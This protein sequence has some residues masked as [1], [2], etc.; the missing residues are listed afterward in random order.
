[1]QWK[2]F[3]IY[4]LSIS[5]TNLAS[6]YLYFPNSIEAS[7]LVSLSHSGPNQAP[8]H[9]SLLTLVIFPKPKSDGHSPAQTF[10]SFSMH[11]GYNLSTRSYIVVL[12]SHLI[13]IG[14]V[15]TLLPNSLVTCI[16]SSVW[17]PEP[18]MLFSS[19]SL[20]TSVTPL[21]LQHPPALLV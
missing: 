1:M 12:F 3:P 2:Y 19:Q 10:P 20:S 13:W 7:S 15:I 8:S 6:L 18:Q 17:F 11:L 4:F 5:W 14:S 21:C 16:L 9:T